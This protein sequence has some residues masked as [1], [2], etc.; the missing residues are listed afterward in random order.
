MKKLKEREV[1]FL[2]AV[3]LVLLLFFSYYVYRGSL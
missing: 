1:A 2:F 3:V